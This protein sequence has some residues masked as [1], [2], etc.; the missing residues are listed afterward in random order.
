[1]I[2]NIDLDSIE[3]TEAF[4]GISIIRDG[5]WFH[6]ARYFDVALD[7][8]G[9]EKLAEFLGLSIDEV[10]PISYDIGSLAVGDE[11]ALK[12]SIPAEP[13]KRFTKEEI[14]TLIFK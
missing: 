13:D 14:M 10:F 8:Y 11:R 7:T 4:V 2:G 3:K 6:L 5:E 1:M 12:G 9:P